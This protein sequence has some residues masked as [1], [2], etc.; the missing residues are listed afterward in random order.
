MHV[1]AQVNKQM[2]TFS[3]PCV[4]LTNIAL[5]KLTPVMINGQES[6]SLSDGS[7]AGLGA[8]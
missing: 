6:F 1:L 8:Q 4:D 2:Y 3:W 7:R 5:V